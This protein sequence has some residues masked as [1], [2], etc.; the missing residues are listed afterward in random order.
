MRAPDLGKELSIS[1][2]SVSNIVL[3]LIIY[4][5]KMGPEKNRIFV[6]QG[7]SVWCK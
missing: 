3:S 2:F 7:T 4:I 1:A 6:S 5:A